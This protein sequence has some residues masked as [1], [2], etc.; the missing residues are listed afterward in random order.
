MSLA[1]RRV[2]PEWLDDLPPDDPQAL[3]SR[4]DLARLNRVMMQAGAMARLLRPLKGMRGTPRI[5]ELGSGD[6]SFMLRVARML[7]RRVPSAEVMLL[8]RGAATMHATLSG[9]RQIGWRATPVESDALD[10][11]RTTPQVDAICANLFLHHFDDAPLTQLLSQAAR[12]TRLFAACEP[13]R[14]AVSLAASR[15]VGAIGCNAVTRHD[16]V[17]SV[18]AGFRDAELSR[19]WPPASGWVLRE[20]RVGPFTH[21]FSAQ[22]NGEPHA[23]L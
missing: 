11:L 21:G 14:D 8:D 7:A 12:C 10:Y 5:L 17:V 15:L 23:S 18:R 9:F 4:R 16:A 3:G 6:G 19:L 13:R 22:W 1:R 2:D 20:S